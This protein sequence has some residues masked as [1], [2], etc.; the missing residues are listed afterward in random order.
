MTG[1]ATHHAASL[2]GA[3]CLFRRCKRAGTGNG[4]LCGRTIELWLV[5]RKN[6]VN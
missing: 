6:P 4:H 3:F 1:T 5:N 2:I